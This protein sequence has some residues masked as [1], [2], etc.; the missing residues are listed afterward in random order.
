[1]AVF[2]HGRVAHNC[3]VGRVGRSGRVQAVLLFGRFQLGTDIFFKVR[4][5][6]SSKKISEHFARK[7]AVYLP[8]CRLTRKLDSFHM[9]KLSFFSVKM[10]F[11]FFL[12]P[13]SKSKLHAISRVAVDT[14]LCG[15]HFLKNK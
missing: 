12:P 2:L 3:T 8:V 9:V 5:T 11:F 4:L 6:N 7:W 14:G 15:R 13:F 1:M 10:K